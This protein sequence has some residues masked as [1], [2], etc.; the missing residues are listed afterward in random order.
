M[1]L[2]VLRKFEGGE[3]I[4]T[5]QENCGGWGFP[6]LFHVKESSRAIWE[7]YGRSI[8]IL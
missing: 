4:S 7:G 2:E 6:L 5:V 3:D 1:D 8:Q